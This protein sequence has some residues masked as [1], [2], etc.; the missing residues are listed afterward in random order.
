MKRRNR[1]AWVVLATSVLVPVSLFF[2]FKTGNYLATVGDILSVFKLQEH[3]FIVAL[4]FAV[5]APIA[6]VAGALLSGSALIASYSISA[7]VQ[8]QERRAVARKK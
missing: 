6:G 2:S 1:I 7:E 8:S 5:F 4:A 3:D